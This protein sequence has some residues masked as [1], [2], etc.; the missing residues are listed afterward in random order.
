[1]FQDVCVVRVNWFRRASELF[2]RDVAGVPSPAG[3]AGHFPSLARP[4]RGKIPYD[5]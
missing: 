4:E 2:R 5:Y 3:G 1:V